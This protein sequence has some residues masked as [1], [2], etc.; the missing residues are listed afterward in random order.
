MPTP[1]SFD[2]QAVGAATDYTVLISRIGQ[3]PTYSSAPAERARPNQPPVT[4]RRTYGGL[5]I[6]FEVWLTQGSAT[7]TETWAELVRRYFSPLGGV[8]ELLATH[9]DGST[10]IEINVEVTSLRRESPRKFAGEFR[11]VEVFWRAQ[12]TSTDSSSPLTV[13]GSYPAL[14][15]IAITGTV[16]NVKRRR[17]TITDQ[18]G[19]GLAN[20]LVQIEFDS[21]GVSAVASSQYI[22]F[23]QGR[24]IPFQIYDP[25]STTTWIYVR[26]DVGPLDSTF[27]DIFYGDGVTN[28]TTNNTL[29]AAGMDLDNAS[30]SN[31]NWMWDLPFTV[32]T[33]PRGACGS[34]TA[35]RAG[36]TFSGTSFA[37]TAEA[38][39]SLDIDIRPDSAHPS[40]INGFVMVVGSAA[41]TSNALTGLGRNDGAPVGN[42]ALYVAYRIAGQVGW[43]VAY[44]ATSLAGVVST[45]I[46]VP[47]AVEILVWVEATDAAADLTMQFTVVTILAL[48]LSSAAVPTVS[49]AAAVT[50]RCLDDNLINSTTGDEIDFDGVYWDD[51]AITIDCLN[52]RISTPTNLLYFAG[53]GIVPTNPDTW[54]RLVVGSNAWSLPTN[55]AA[56]FSWQSRFAV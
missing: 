29:E 46:S 3:A 32:S 13:A 36:R 43:T 1:T 47:A 15:S 50:A 26:I 35:T 38:G 44:T 31:T 27:V 54:M 37:I 53:A 12:A 52:Q 21:T 24:A 7:A 51:E 9:D 56:E 45:A 19:R 23:Y 48:A 16:S 39:A 28:V 34:W 22:V 2:G 14:P 49:V 5:T 41:A 25:N 17:V 55:G 11:A 4:D 33:N 20:Y 6:P 18:G 8:R 10:A 40:D 42:Y 30:F